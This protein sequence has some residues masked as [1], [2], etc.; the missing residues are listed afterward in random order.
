MT[1]S[2]V[3]GGMGIGML[4]PRQPWQNNS[5]GG[6]KV[7]VSQASPTETSGPQITPEASPAQS[8]FSALLGNM[9]AGGLTLDASGPSQDQF[10][11]PPPVQG[12]SGQ[13]S[14]GGSFAGALDDIF[15]SGV[16]GVQDVASS[17]Q[18]SFAGLDSA[19][20]ELAGGVT[21]ATAIQSEPAS[22]NVEPS[23][24]GLAPSD[25]ASASSV[26]AQ[27]SFL[28]D[29]GNLVSAIGA[30]DGAGSQ[31]AA[32]ALL[33]DIESGAEAIQTKLVNAISQP[34]S[35]G[36]GNSL[37]NVISSYFQWS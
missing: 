35:A 31:A 11:A 16:A 24:G 33:G 8:G 12:S 5:V 27:P 32:S 18:A 26:D 9:A 21:A 13:G 22:A 3:Y 29:L 4:Q 28:S 1:I 17:I 20:P 30:G 34:F 14:F 2:G 7:E 36:Q 10:F 19:P 6:N 37:S 25:T 15:S 23:A